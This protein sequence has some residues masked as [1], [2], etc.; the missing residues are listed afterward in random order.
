MFNC[1]C[2]YCI[3]CIEIGCDI[4]EIHVKNIFM[5]NDYGQKLTDINKQ[6]FIQKLRIDLRCTRRQVLSHGIMS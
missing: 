5:C 2:N 1:T 4:L 6:L 3:V